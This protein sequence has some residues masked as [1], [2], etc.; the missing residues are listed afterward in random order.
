MFINFI[1]QNALCQFVMEP[2]RYGKN[3]LDLVLC[4]DRLAIFDLM[5]TQPFSTSILCSLALYSVLFY[6]HW[7]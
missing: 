1:K 2:T 4:N 7:H 5:V 6:V 3:I